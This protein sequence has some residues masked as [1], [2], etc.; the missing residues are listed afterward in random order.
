VFD[1]VA[2]NALIIE[3]HQQG[4]ETFDVDCLGSSYLTVTHESV[5]V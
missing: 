5:L 1:L 3:N 4:L 2:H